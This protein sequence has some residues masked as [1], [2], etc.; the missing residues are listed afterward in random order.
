MKKNSCFKT[1]FVRQNVEI[2][3]HNVQSCAYHVFV[4]TFDTKVTEYVCS[5]WVFFSSDKFRL[6]TSHF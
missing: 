6:V 2:L 1:S 3:K 4:P 5:G